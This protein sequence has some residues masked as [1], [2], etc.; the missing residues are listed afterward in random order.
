MTIL[1]L[2]RFKTAL[3]ATAVPSWKEASKKLKI[4]HFALAILT[5]PQDLS[6]GGSHAL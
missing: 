1:A 2:K 4:K 3:R 5:N 6:R